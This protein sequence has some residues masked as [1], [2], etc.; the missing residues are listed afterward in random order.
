VFKCLEAGCDGFGFKNGFR[1]F[2]DL[3]THYESR[4]KDLFSD[5]AGLTG[6]TGLR[7]Y[8]KA[9]CGS[10]TLRKRKENVLDI[11]RRIHYCNIK[12][13]KIEL[14]EGSVK[15]IFKRSGTIEQFIL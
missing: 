8:T 2:S 12:D 7:F 9:V 3:K 13:F 4:H 14:G 15:V 6:L 5:A 10:E 1:R 11:C